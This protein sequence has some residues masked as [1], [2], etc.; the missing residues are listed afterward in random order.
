MAHHR[1]AAFHHPLYL[2]RHSDTTLKFDRLG[3]GFLNKESRI[4]ERILNT[5]VVGHK[6][7]ITNYHCLLGTSNHRFGVMQHLCHGYRYR[8]FIAQD[9]HAQAISD[10]NQRYTHLVNYLGR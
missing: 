2:F 9:Y 10:Q 7:H 6:G 5:D 3:A 1:N 4:P 8:R